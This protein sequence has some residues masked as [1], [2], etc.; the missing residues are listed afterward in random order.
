MLRKLKVKGS[1]SNL[2]LLFK[3]VEALDLPKVD[4]EFAKLFG[5]EDRQHDALNKEVRQNMHVNLIKH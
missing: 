5:I 4:E 1:S 2:R 3:K